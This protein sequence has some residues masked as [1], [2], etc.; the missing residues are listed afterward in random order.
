ML[1]RRMHKWAHLFDSPQ[2]LVCRQAS[3]DQVGGGHRWRASTADRAMHINL[4]TAFDLRPNEVAAA[5]Q[6]VQRRWRIVDCGKLQMTFSADALRQ[7]AAF[8][9]HIEDG[10]DA[11]VAHFAIA[12][13]IM[14]PAHMQL[15]CDR[16][17]PPDR[18]ARR[19]PRKLVEQTQRQWQGSATQ[20]ASQAHQGVGW[21]MGLCH[22]ADYS[23]AARC[24]SASQA[25]P[26]C[27]R[28]A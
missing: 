17:E 6:I 28:F 5:A 21:G 22:S 25:A 18:S 11:I 19:P 14:L 23:T 20:Q 3:R 9:A 12:A 13:S 26:I 8:S 15:R 10:S 7:V 1:G 27:A 2:R 4:A 16:A 24:G